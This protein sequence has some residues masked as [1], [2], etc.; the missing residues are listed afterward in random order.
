[1]EGEKLKLSAWLA[2]VLTDKRIWKMFNVKKN[3]NKAIQVD[4]EI[5]H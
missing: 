5:K 3:P 4:K 2:L 1:M